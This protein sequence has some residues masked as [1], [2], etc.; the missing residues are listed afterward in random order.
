M[1]APAS[2]LQFQMALSASSVLGLTINHSTFVCTRVNEPLMTSVAGACWR[3]AR[4][5]L[6]GNTAL[7]VAVQRCRHAGATRVAVV[8]AAVW[9]GCRTTLCNRSTQCLPHVLRPHVPQAT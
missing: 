8:G 2:L 9:A 4:W 5:G 7:L 3:A 6:G 1:P